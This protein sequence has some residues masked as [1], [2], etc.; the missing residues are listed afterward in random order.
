MR[1]ERLNYNKIKI[2]LTQDD[3]T[4][5]GL[6]K[7]DIWKDSLKWHQLFHDMLEEASEE[8]GVEIH[9]SVAVEIFSMQAQ[10]MIMIV[11]MEE[12]GEEDLLQDGFIEMQLLMDGSEEILF[13]IKDFEVVIQLAKR[14]KYLN[15]TNSSLYAYKE[16]YYFH[17]YNQNADDV[18]KLIALLAEY[19]N[20]S[21]L[22]IHMLEE[23]GKEIIKDHA[24]EKLNHFFR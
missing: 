18:N 11:T 14:L 8:F 16:S 24:V 6:T 10:G 22:S 23:Y 4:E 19:G 15:I 9:G 17:L 21:L 3:L 20:P 13:E 5:R 12:Q 2:F 1:L 7:D